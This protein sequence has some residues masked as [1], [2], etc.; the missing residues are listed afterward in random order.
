MP[1]LIAWRYDAARRCLNLV[2][3]SIELAAKEDP[4]V[5]KRRDGEVMEVGGATAAF[6]ISEG[7]GDGCELPPGKAPRRVAV[8]YRGEERSRGLPSPDRAI[9][10]VLVVEPFFA[11]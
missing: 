7:V 2:D 4:L 8:L 5:A 9:G 3:R 1:D 6:S 11:G 10:W